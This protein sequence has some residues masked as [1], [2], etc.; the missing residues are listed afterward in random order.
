MV[1]SSVSE[2]VRGRFQQFLVY[3]PIISL[4]KNCT[5]QWSF[6]ISILNRNAFLN[7]F[8]QWKSFNSHHI[9]FLINLQGAK[10]KMHDSK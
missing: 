3:L 10:S 2:K 5:L 7:N 6:Q 8:P 1:L 4:K 9:I